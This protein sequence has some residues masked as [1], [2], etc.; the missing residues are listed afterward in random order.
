M[1]RKMKEIGVVIFL[2]IKNGIPRFPT[3]LRVIERKVMT[4][5]KIIKKY[6]L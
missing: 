2:R 3:K 4:K 1:V 5:F 6:I